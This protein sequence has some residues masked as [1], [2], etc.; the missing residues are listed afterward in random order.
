MKQVSSG[1]TGGDN[2]GKYVAVEVKSVPRHIFSSG[3][4]LS[5]SDE[6]KRFCYVI[7]GSKLRVE[8]IA[9]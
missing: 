2:L 5:N 7:R 4:V 6:N 1:D 9:M 3:D 8:H